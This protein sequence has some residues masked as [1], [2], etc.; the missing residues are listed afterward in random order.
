MQTPPYLEHNNITVRNLDETLRF[1]QTAM[2]EFEIRGRGTHNDRPWVHLGTQDTYIA[3][4]EAIVESNCDTRYTATGFNHMGFVVD[5]VEVLAKRL[6]DAGYERNYPLTHDEFRYR[7]YF[8]DRDGNEYEFVQY[9]SDK[10]EERN[11]Y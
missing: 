3:I 10:P 2:P 5:D 7:E 9:L 6:L 8:N 11:A 1:L 4:N